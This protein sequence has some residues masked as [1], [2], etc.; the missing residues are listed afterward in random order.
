MLAD[1]SFSYGDMTMMSITVDR[2]NGGQKVFA[3]HRDIICKSSQYM[4]RQPAGLVRLFWYPVSFNIYVNWLYTGAIS[5]HHS[6]QHKNLAKDDPEYFSLLELFDLGRLLGDQTFRNAVLSAFLERFTESKVEGRPSYPGLSCIN[7][8][9]P[10]YGSKSI[11]EANALQRL[12]VDIYAREDTTAMIER[13]GQ[14]LPS[15]FL[16][17]LAC[18]EQEFRMQSEKGMS[19]QRACEF[20]AH[21]PNEACSVEERASKRKRTE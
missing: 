17:L 18:R 12:I 20:H 13:M 6:H 5:T 16:T 1:I 15:T 2:A 4:D 7:C 8:V 11:K 3:V 9:F 14:N 19:L 21:G 10:R